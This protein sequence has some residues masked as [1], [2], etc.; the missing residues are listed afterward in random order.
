[1]ILSSLYHLSDLLSRTS[2]H[3]DVYLLDLY[4]ASSVQIILFRLPPS[5]PYISA[6]YYIPVAAETD[7]RA[8][9]A[10]TAVEP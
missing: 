4:C 3:R 10:Q 8:L 7:G 9:A 6:M 5:S 2:H 1:M